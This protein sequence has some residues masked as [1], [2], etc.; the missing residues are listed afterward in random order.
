LVPVMPVNAAGSRIEPPVSVA[1][2]AGAMRAATAALEPPEEPPG[3]APLSQ[4]LS[5]LPKAL[6]S[7]DEPIANSSQLSL[8]RQ[9]MPACFRLV[10]HGGV[11]RAHV[12]RQH[13][14]AGG[15][16]PLAGDEDVLVRDR[17]AEQGTGLAA[18]APSVGGAGQIERDLGPHVE[19]GIQVA[20]RSMRA[21][22]QLGQFDRRDL[23]GIEQAAEFGYR[24]MGEVAHCCVT[25]KRK[26]GARRSGRRSDEPAALTR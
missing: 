20:V 18:R 17:H 4:G 16:G 7:L 10:D 26:G 21:E 9:T 25:K 3:T 15:A 5:T 14:A 22:E 24:R 8:P 2:A 23:P 12:A 13:L 1:V 6:F 11:E 19:K